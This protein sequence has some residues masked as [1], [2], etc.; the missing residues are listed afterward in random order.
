MSGLYIKQHAVLFA[1]FI[2]GG[3]VYWNRTHK[4]LELCLPVHAWLRITLC[5]HKPILLLVL[6]EVCGSQHCKMKV[7]VHFYQQY[8]RLT[9]LCQLHRRGPHMQVYLCQT[10][11]YLLHKLYTVELSEALPQL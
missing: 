6:T 2:A 5:T 9:I 1:L 11:A 3:S 8:H 10:I 7:L 4:L